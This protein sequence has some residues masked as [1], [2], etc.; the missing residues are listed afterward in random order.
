[1][2][3]DADGFASGQKR[4]RGA[5]SPRLVPALR[6]LS[7][8]R[9]TWLSQRRPCL[10]TNAAGCGRQKGASRHA[11]RTKGEGEGYTEGRGQGDGGCHDCDVQVQETWSCD[12]KF[13][14]TVNFLPAACALPGTSA[15]TWTSGLACH[16]SCLRHL[17]MVRAGPEGVE[18][19]FRF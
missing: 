8:W 12:T 5:K 16:A 9:Q 17:V 1:M 15:G 4:A 19:T 14:N 7:T 2:R 6:C 18:F 11:C 10:G 3:D 13:M